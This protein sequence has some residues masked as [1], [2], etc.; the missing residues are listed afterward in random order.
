MLKYILDQIDLTDMNKAFNLTAAKDTFFLGVHRQFS[1]I[2]HMIGH[3][4][5]IS[6]FKK[7]ETILRIISNH[8]SMKVEINK[9]KKYKNLQIA[10]LSDT[11]LRKQWVKNKSKGKLRK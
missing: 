3:K 9:R 5:S 8:N 11:L 4:T 2:E 6:K 7:M 1:R 10:K